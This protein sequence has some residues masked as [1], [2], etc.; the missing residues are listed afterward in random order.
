MAKDSFRFARIG[1]RE[2]AAEY[3]A[4]L[5]QGLKRGEVSLE[6]GERTLHLTPAAELK[7]ELKVK[8]RDEKGKISIEIG[9]KRKTTTRAA[10]LAVGTTARP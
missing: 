3:L 9:W 5:G 2:E 10:D 1:S 6:S 8:D 4:S 7:I